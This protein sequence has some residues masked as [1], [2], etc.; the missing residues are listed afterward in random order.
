MLSEIKNLTERYLELAETIESLLIE[1]PFQISFASWQ[2]NLTLPLI[3]GLV[4]HLLVFADTDVRENRLM[5]HCRA[6]T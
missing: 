4:I 5:Q 2:V 3:T 6:S 1:R